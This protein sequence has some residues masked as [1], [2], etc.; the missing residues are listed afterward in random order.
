ME[1]VNMGYHSGLGWALNK[2][3]S[4]LVREEDTQRY[5]K[6][7]ALVRTEA[8]TEATQPPPQER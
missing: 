6:G 4:V 7:E 1:L 2:I 5:T 3:T 8:E